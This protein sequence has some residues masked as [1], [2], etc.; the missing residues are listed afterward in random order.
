MHVDV[1][2]LGRLRDGGGWRKLGHDHP[3]ARANHA[4]RSA[5][6]RVGHEF[7]HVAIDDHSRLAYVEVCDDET[8]ETAAAFW[9]RAVAWFADH[10]IDS[11]TS[12]LTDNGA[13]YRSRAWTSALAVTGTTPKRTRPYRPQTNGK[14][15]R[16]NR[17][18]AEECLYAD[19]YTSAAARR[20]ALRAWLHIYN[21]HRAHTA[22]GGQPPIGRVNNVPGHY[23]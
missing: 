7:L 12:A 14:V 17:T 9:C 19:T 3:T 15:E 23:T 20:A 1:K 18:M 5:G 4:A 22:I 13:C 21:H 8:A 6:R 11:I 10:G 2:K 16:F